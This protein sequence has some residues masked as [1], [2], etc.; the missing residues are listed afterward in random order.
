MPDSLFKVQASWCLTM[1]NSKLDLRVSRR[2]AHF[3]D[4]CN[5]SKA[6]IV[7]LLLPFFSEAPYP[8]STLLGLAPF[9]GVVDFTTANS[10]RYIAA[11]QKN[12][13]GDVTCSDAL[14]APVC[15]CTVLIMFRIS[16]GS[17]ILQHPPH[18]VDGQR[19]HD[20]GG[21]VCRYIKQ[22]SPFSSVSSLSPLLTCSFPVS[23]LS[24]S[25]SRCRSKSKT[26][27]LPTL[28]KKMATMAFTTISTADSSR[29]RVRTLA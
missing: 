16:R 17:L 12:T 26:R 1:L 27:P 21:M 3:V 13:S 10:S 8:C 18:A 23:L 20:A 11:R 4:L 2:E 14:A 7:L 15:L 28:E 25:C 5:P 29:S 22:M 9:R 19:A 24:T 6:S